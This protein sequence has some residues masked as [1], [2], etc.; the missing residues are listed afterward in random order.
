MQDVAKQLFTALDSL[1]ESPQFCMSGS[2][3]SVLPGLVVDG[4]GNVGLPVS[5]TEA[6]KLIEQATQAPYGLG[7]E[8]VVDTNVRRVWQIDPDKFSLRNSAWEK[9]ISG[10]CENIK[11][12]FGIDKE[13]RCDLY[14]L[15]IYE[16]GS[17]FAPHRD[18]EKADGMFATLVVCLPSPHKGGT[19][20]V[21]HDGRSQEVE[22]DGEFKIQY[23]AF[24]ADCEHEVKPVTEGYRVCLVYNLALADR[25]RQLLAPRS[26]KKAEE[27]ADLLTGIFADASQDKIVIPLKHEYTKSGLGFG[28]LKGTDRSLADVLLRAAKQLNYHI[29]LC[30]LTFHQ[31][32]EA[33]YDSIDY[34]WDR[35]DGGDYSDADM[36]EVYDE[37]L[38]LDNWIDAHDSLKEFGKMTI[39][40]TSELISEENLTDFPYEQDVSGATGNEGVSIERW[41]RQAMIVLWPHEHY[42]RILADQGQDSAVPA[43]EELIAKV[44]DPPIDKECHVFA[45]EIVNNWKPRVRYYGIDSSKSA[46]MLKHLECIA[47]PALINSFIRGVLTRDYNGTEGTILSKICDKFGWETFA[48]SLTNFVTSQLPESKTVSLKKTISIFEEL[49]CSSVRMTSERWVLC[50][51]LA[52]EVEHLINEW[53]NFKK[54]DPWFSVG[55]ESREGVIESLVRALCAIEETDLLA[56]LLSHFFLT[57]NHYNL[58]KVLIPTAQKIK[59]W[60]ELTPSQ[61][62]SHKN[63][64]EHCIG[65]LQDL[66]EKP[67]EEPTNWAQDTKLNCKCEDCKELQKFIRDANEQVYRF[68]IRK[69]RRRHLHRQIETHRCDMDDVTERKGSPQTL[70]CTKNRASYEKRK[71]Q[72]V[73]NTAL[74]RE[75]RCMM[76][77][78][79]VVLS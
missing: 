2:L 30:L 25:K 63:I 56:K 13:L 65:E 1:D 45:Q 48:K 77:D 22:C 53:D 26:G 46:D 71:E 31:S 38:T 62:E 10:I 41:Y 70:V 72:F 20:V 43:L 16:K 42:F 5:P 21:N 44:D 67:V 28:L 15:L 59:K 24:Y 37:D 68:R 57:E 4:V 78:V 36:G 12:E 60:N 7:E 50:K 76:Y 73:V 8:T 34:R 54:K 33:D 17:F 55:Q 32:G 29:H 58:H 66:T 23:A 14:K 79:D 35:H 64:L 11:S 9:L 18:S 61:I 39:S 51:A 19:L 3:E 40:E 47:E 49:C 27:V 74:L 6:Q 52:A 69:D 75:L